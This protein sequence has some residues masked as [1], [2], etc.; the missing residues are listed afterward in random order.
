M[1]IK[2]LKMEDLDSEIKNIENEIDV[3][4][5]KITELEIKKN[6]K[7]NIKQKILYNMYQKGIQYHLYRDYRQLVDVSIYNKHIVIK[8]NIDVYCLNIEI[9]H[10]VVGVYCVNNNYNSIN[11][12]RTDI[13]CRVRVGYGKNT[14]IDNVISLC[15]SKLQITNINDEVLQILKKFIIN[16]ESYAR[17]LYNYNYPNFHKYR[18]GFIFS[19]CNSKNRI[20]PRGIDKIILQKILFFN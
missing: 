10:N 15:K 13:V 12:N 7:N 20:F 11:G 8:L 18:I 16:Y 19:L 3:L 2:K 4:K 1:K 9:S 17:F 14:N 6:N 5:Y